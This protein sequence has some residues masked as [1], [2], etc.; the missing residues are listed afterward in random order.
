M[1]FKIYFTILS[2]FLYIKIYNKISKIISKIAYKKICDN[3]KALYYGKQ[4]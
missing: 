2:K 4:T 3:I 1:L